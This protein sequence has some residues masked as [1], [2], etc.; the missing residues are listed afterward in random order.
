MHKHGET[1]N[2]LL[3]AI[4]GLIW[5]ASFLFIAEG[6]K[7]VGPNGVAFVRLFIGFAALALFPAARKPVARSAWPGI[8]LLGVLWF[9][10]P[11][12][13]F[14]FAEQ[15]VS[16]AL[17]GML[18]AAVPL[19][20]AIV[21]ALIARRVPERPVN[22]GLSVGLIGAA[23]IAWPAIHQG[24]SSSAGVL[25][26][27]AAVISYG[28]ALNLAR[29]LQQRYGALPV[30]LRAQAV[31]VILTAPLGIPGVLAAR[32]TPAPFFS[33]LMLGAFGT[34]VAFVSLA[35]AAGRV[36][37]TRASS[38]AFLIPPVALLLGVLVRGE[39]VATLSIAGSAVCVA[40]AWL[41]RRART[42]TMSRMLRLSAA[43]VVLAALLIPLA[44][45]SGSNDGLLRTRE[46]VWRA[47]FAGDTKALGEL[48]PAETI[49]MSGGEEK[50]KNQADVLRTA[51]EFHAKGGKLL[52]LDF[53]RTDVQHFGDVAIVWSSY[54]LEIEIDGKRSSGSSRVTEI[55]VW[56]HGRWTNPGWHTDPEK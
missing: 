39:H 40:G 42:T 55:F 33:L 15:R 3:I 2:E 52:R 10:F 18:N 9:A 13:L 54:V 53:P 23:L 47:W 43:I 16:S 26:I 6:L 38:A 4:P 56:R 35:A 8:A 48:V 51:V 50:W 27:L 28:F 36:G 31:A 19:F 49:V 14:P 44:G 21:A 20:T 25:M 32:W 34:G 29:P 11:L 12:S 30:I 46:R 22:V 1:M 37:A 7:A 45:A 41:M 24:H 17:T 5:G